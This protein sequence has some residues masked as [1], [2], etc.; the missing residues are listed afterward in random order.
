MVLQIW[1]TVLSE[2]FRSYNLWFVSRFGGRPMHFFGAAGTV[3]FIIGFLSAL[4]L[5]FLIDVARGMY[6]HPD[7]R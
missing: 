3:M 4:W 7:C 5:G 6:G 1:Q 2:D